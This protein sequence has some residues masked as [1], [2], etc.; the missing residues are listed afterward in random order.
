M[1]VRITRFRSVLAL[2]L[3]VLSLGC[4]ARE[5][6]DVAAVV[7]R[8]GEYAQSGDMI[9]Q[10][11]L[12]LADRVG[13]WDDVV[14]LEDTRQEMA[15]QQA[16]MD[17]YFA[18]NPGV[19]FKVDIDDLHVRVWEGTAVATFYMRTSLIKPGSPS[20]PGGA[21]PVN[22]SVAKLICQTLV[23]RD[24]AWKIAATAVS[25]LKEKAQ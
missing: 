19:K 22:K 25:F 8:Y 16:A 13:V 15:R 1:I 14:H 6:D 20:I 23:K 10:G 12:M 18:R 5:E 7:H 3:A 11:R 4:H 2:W 21:E 17:K 9:A 24:G